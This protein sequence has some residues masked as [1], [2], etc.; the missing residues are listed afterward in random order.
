MKIRNKTSWGIF[1]LLLLIVAGCGGGGTET[2][3]A[4]TE[5][6]DVLTLGAK[7]ETVASALVP[8][9]NS[10]TGS[11]VALDKA[12]SYGTS[13]DWSSYLESTNLTFLTDIFGPAG[14]A[15][16][17]ETR[18]RVAVGTFKTTVENIFAAD[19]DIDCTG[20]AI[21]NEGDAIDIAF[22]GSISNGVA[23][24][25]YL[26][27][28]S[29]STDGSGRRTE[30]YGRDGQGVIRVVEMESR[31][32]PTDSSNSELGDEYQAYYVF[33]V[34]Y[35]EAAADAGTQGYL[36]MR[37]AK[38]LIYSGA[39]GTIGTGDDQFYRM[40]TR[41]TGEVAIDEAGEVGMGYSDFTTTKYDRAMDNED[42]WLTLIT[43]SIGRGSYSAG[44]H[45]L[46][47]IDSDA[48]SLVGKAGTYCIQSSSGSLP[49]YA[50][51]ESCASLESSFAWGD[52][53]FPFAIAPAL[54]GD[55]ELKEFFE[56]NDTDMIAE[57]GSNFA[58]P[59]YESIEVTESTGE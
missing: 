47:D 13:D 36:D 49:S 3:S 38:A 28:I 6:V 7:L 8:D 23:G 52:S 41:V 10:S 56:G 55:F 54:E 44:S 24:D 50:Q 29:D 30:L 27:C 40:R 1:I 32:Y 5:P 42:D 20:A 59:A 16:A 46:F 19:P 2:G 33:Q 11:Q 58:I 25:R 15:N 17:P 51:A 34:A 53:A 14:V 26:D 35:S 9:I 37:Y 45:S 43:K 12:I 22:Y 48:S 31:I 57:D 39:D 18:I 4:G 21:L